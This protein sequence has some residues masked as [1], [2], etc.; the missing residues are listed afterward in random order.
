MNKKENR[1]AVRQATEKAV[2]RDEQDVYKRQAWTMP[3]EEI[4]MM[5]TVTIFDE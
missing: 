4:L 2:I 3:H 5:C 1:I